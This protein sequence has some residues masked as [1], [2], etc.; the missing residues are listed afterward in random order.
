MS[1]EKICKY[2]KKPID[3]NAK[4]CPFCHCKQKLPIWV[5]ILI[6]VVGLGI[7][8]SIFGSSDPV[9]SDKKEESQQ[10]RRK[11]FSQHEMVT[12][13]DV[14]YTIVKVEKTQG[15]NMFLNPREGYEYV[16][17]TLR[18]ENN[19]TSKISYNALDWKMVN[20]DGV[21]DGW[22]TITAEDDVNL[23][24]GD[25][26]AGGRV[27][28]VL[29]WEQKI[30]DDNLRLRYYETFISSDYVFQIKLD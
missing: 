6:F 10:E 23:S 25:L 12:Y 4:V 30:N 20:A 27:E 19:S 7:L 9:G 5:I 2:C 17:V 15:T 11:D 1:N 24:S 8:G 21:E 16:K 18:I 28:G 3:K 14:N 29:V 26:D 22:G 13:K